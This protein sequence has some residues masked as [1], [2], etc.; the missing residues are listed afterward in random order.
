MQT[1]V[2]L[3]NPEQSDE[4]KVEGHKQAEGPSEVRDAL[5]FHAFVGVDA[6]RHRGGVDGAHTSRCS[7]RVHAAALTGHDLSLTPGHTHRFLSAAKEAASNSHLW[8]S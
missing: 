2:E 8:S 7:S 6:S 5:L 1:Y 4:E 3:N